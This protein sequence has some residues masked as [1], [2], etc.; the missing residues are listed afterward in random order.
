MM[1]SR[2]RT[3]GFSAGVVVYFIFRFV[4]FLIGGPFLQLGSFRYSDVLHTLGGFLIYGPL[5]VF[6]LMDP[7][8]FSPI[9]YQI[10]SVMSLI[11][12]ALIYGLI[13]AYISDRLSKKG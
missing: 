2:P 1:R 6:L 13:G 3:W 12:T 10:I 7:I 8:V 4:V 11:T 9:A 5:A